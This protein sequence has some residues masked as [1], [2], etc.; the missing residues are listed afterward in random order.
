MTD[1]FYGKRIVVTGASSGIGRAGALRIAREGGTV[2]ATGRDEAKLASLRDELPANALVL[3]NDVAD[4]DTGLELRRR[5]ESGGHIDGLW[6]N[7]GYAGQAAIGDVSAEFFDNMMAANVRG[8]LLQMA[9]L[10]DLLCDSASVV[11]TSSTTAFRGSRNSSVYAAT[12]GAI[13][14]VMRCWALG[15][16]ERG[17]RVNALIPGPI[18]SNFRAFLSPDARKRVEVDVTSTLPLARMG[19]SEEAASVALFLLS[20]DSS[21][22]TGAEFAVDGG[23]LL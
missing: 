7:A 19:K 12:K 10:N 11:V 22:V 15:L 14:S 17:I 6:L 4:P 1:R 9:A 16:S 5:I 13:I 2:I 21:F 18:A 23:R 8:P 3:C 20:D